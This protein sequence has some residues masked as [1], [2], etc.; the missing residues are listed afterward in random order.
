MT[1]PF[2]IKKRVTQIFGNKLILNGVDVYGQWNLKGHNGIDY[3]LP[4]DTPLYAPHDGKIIE[5]IYNKGGYGWYLKIENDKEGSVLAH[6]RKFVVKTG[7][8][9]KQGQL[10]GYSNNSGWSTGPH[11]HWGYYL[12]PRDRSNGY[13]G[14]INQAPYLTEGST[15][16]YNAEGIKNFLISEGYTYPNTHLE[17]IKVLQSSDLKLKSGKYIIKEDCDKKD[18]LKQECEDKLSSLRNKQ[19]E[20]ITNLKANN[21]N[22][23]KNALKKAKED[24]SVSEMESQIAGYEKILQT[25]A[26]KI[27]VNIEKVLEALKIFK[28]IGGKNG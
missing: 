25:T 9:V 16:S 8:Y 1:L 22:D 28:K 10:I 4:N 3:G 18:N 11:L 23:I 5:A 12:K 2:K 17:V 21:K 15:L 24:W 14:Y 13:N 20:V 7:D 26:Y 19:T 6:M 27:A